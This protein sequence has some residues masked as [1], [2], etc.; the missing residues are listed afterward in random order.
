M[1]ECVWHAMKEKIINLGYSSLEVDELIKVSKNIEKD[2]NKLKNDYPIQYLIGYV[3]FYGYKINVNDSV[4]IPRYETEYL[5]EKTIN[6]INNI[7]GNKKINILDLGCGSGA[8]SII[9]SKK[10]N[11]NVFGIDISEKALKVAKNNAKENN[12]NIKFIKNDMLDNISD[13]YD[14]I[15]S[16]PPYISEEEN[17]MDRVKLYEPNI[18]L[19]APNNGLYYYEKILSNI[20][21]NL[22]EKYLI[23]FEIGITQSS[24]ISKMIKKYLPNSKYYIEKDLT[25]RDRYIFIT[26]E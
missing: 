19:Y 21:N 26:S 13:K 1:K 16:N 17:I 2:Y 7:F 14:V 12:T 3:N 18:A 4:L 5:V 23:A 8:I 15:I 9:L 11:S 24:E 25:N 6:Y 10:T 22:K 20:K